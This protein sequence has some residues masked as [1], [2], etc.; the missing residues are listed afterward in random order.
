MGEAQLALGGLTEGVT[1]MDMAAA[2]AVFP[3]QGT[4][5]APKTYTMVT[6]NGGQ[7]LLRNETEE[8]T[9]V[10]SQ[11]TTYY[12]TE[13]LQRVVS[14]GTGKKA[15]FSGQEIAGKTGTTTSRKD[16]WFVG[17][18]PYYTAAIWTGYDRQERL[19]NGLNNPSPV[20]WNQVMSKVHQ[21]LQYK[22]FDKPDNL[23]TITYC[24]SS[25]MLPGPYCSG[26]LA[27]G[28]FLPEDAPTGTC[29][30]H[31]GQS[32][33]SSTGD[34]NGSSNG[35]STTNDGGGTTTDNGNTGDNSGTTTPD[36]GTGDNSGTT[37]PAE[38]PPADTASGET[39]TPRRR[40]EGSNIPKAS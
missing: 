7:V 32:S 5:R 35:G 26:H 36:T 15:N 29:T 12:M 38:T 37:T 14:N 22:D 17:Y 1:T 16:L 13:M 2:Y 3:N 25:G 24:L 19:A 23:K 30:Y 9:N 27:T 6:D 33:N 10:L 40:R 18:T 39:A 11:R 20:L 8:E 4:Y 31:K 34:G 21:G 28:T